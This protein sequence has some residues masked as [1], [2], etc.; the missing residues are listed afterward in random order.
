MTRVA[1]QYLTDEQERYE[2]C[3][4][5]PPHISILSVSHYFVNRFLSSL[6]ACPERRLL[7]QVSALQRHGDLSARDEEAWNLR[8]GTVSG[9]ALTRPLIY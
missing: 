5:P 3:T 8:P 1:A 4:K 9:V 2:L 6:D 7:L